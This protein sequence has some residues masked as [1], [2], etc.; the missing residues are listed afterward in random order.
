MGGVTMN[1]AIQNSIVSAKTAGLRYVSDRLPGIRR[2]GAGKTFRYIGPNGSV[3]RDPAALSR[4]R[5]LAIPPAWTDVWICP[6]A[7]GH[8]QATGRDARNRKQYRYHPSWREVRDGGKFDRMADF[9]KALPKIRARVKRD[10]ARPGLPR[11]RVL[12]TIVRLLE[13]TNIRV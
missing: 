11:Q 12:A 8:L 5:S 2:L 9:E 7:E 6:L 4:I 3:V 13:Q 1:R 10:L